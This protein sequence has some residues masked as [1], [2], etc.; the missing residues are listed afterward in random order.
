M[1][2]LMCLTGSR[3]S[4]YLKLPTTSARHDMVST[5]TAPAAEFLRFIILLNGKSHSRP[6]VRDIIAHFS[7]CGAVDRGVWTARKFWLGHL[8]AK[9]CSHVPDDSSRQY[10]PNARAFRAC[11]SS[12]SY[13]LHDSFHLPNLVRS[14][15]IHLS[16]CGYMKPLHARESRESCQTPCHSHIKA[17]E[18]LRA[19]Q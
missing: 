19:C 16:C 1:V 3:W 5:S 13:T 6:T 9:G 18:R 11:R 17:T 12:S 7:F 15:P 8:L 4:K 10:G 14:R 2:L